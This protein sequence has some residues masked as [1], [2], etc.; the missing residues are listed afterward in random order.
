MNRS[1]YRI[2]LVEDQ[3]EDREAI[4]REL[5]VACV[6]YVL[7][8]VETREDFAAQLKDFLPDIILSDFSLTRFSA[9]EAMTV[10]GHYRK[11]IPFLLV[12]NTQSEEVAVECIKR[13]ADDYIV[14]SSLKRL[15]F[16]VINAILKRE[17]QREKEAARKELWAREAQVRLI[18]E[19]TRDLI[20]V[21][22]TK[23][24]FTY[25]S[26]SFHRTLGHA[27]ETLV[28][29]KAFRYV[30]PED[31]LTIQT[32]FQESFL[33]KADRTAQFRYRHAGG[34]WRLFE[35]VVNW[36]LD[37]T[38]NP[39]KAVVVARDI[40]DRKHMEDQIRH[41]QKME[42]VGR[43]AGGVAHDFN[44]LLTAINGYSDLLLRS[45]DK[46]DPR[47]ADVEEIKDTAA[48]AAALTQQLLAFS[49]RQ[50]TNPTV[51]DINQMLSH[52]EKMLRRLIGEDIRLKTALAPG[53]Y[54][55]KADMGQMEQVLLNLS[56]NAR[57]AMPNGGTLEISTQNWDVASDEDDEV[58]SGAYA[59]LVIT[60]TGCGMDEST[61]S[62]LFEPFFTTKEKGRGT[63]LGLS[64][65]YGIVQEAGGFI[66]VTSRPGEGTS[67]RIYF[68]MIS[69]N[70][71]ELTKTPE[72]EEFLKGNEVVVLAEDDRAVRT[73]AK[74]VLIQS[75]YNVL[76]AA[77]GEEALALA[78]STTGPI[79]LL[80]SDVVMNGIAGPELARRMILKRPGLK[81]LYLSGYMELDTRNSVL[82]EAQSSFL[83]K[84]F[85]PRD[86][87]QKVR[88]TL[89]GPEKKEEKKTA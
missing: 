13:G 66:H 37:E 77:S 21:L 32:L 51:V 60:D 54:R 2:L 89:D 49:R 12:T 61:L 38:G 85:R 22:D 25:V 39:M 63:G 57:D 14:K 56:V 88:E 7:K 80:V 42:A 4:E 64:T 20:Y 75:G 44:N 31:E 10:L 48:R 33:A 28:G 18:A 34:A 53:L 83:A 30:H 62:H 68:P 65:V 47:R 73:L 27:P 8:I 59:K 23:G 11:D 24:Q 55:V 6:S 71:T 78:E 67:F 15:P 76:D 86:L 3:P 70:V 41:A 1:P 5:T 35:S 84:P 19:Q 40:E 81:V 50:I 58:P 17:I 69:E 46:M 82:R 79:D 87:V 45:L 29:R 72:T 16:A 74:R 52:L 26:P 36:A 43:L 9:L